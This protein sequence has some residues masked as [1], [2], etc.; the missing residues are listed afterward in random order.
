M[1]GTCPNGVTL[2]P[3]SSYAMPPGAQTNPAYYN[4]S[5]SRTSA[6]PTPAGQGW[7]T[8]N[9]GGFSLGQST[10]QSVVTPAAAGQNNVIPVN[11]NQVST[12]MLAQNQ[13][14]SNSVNYSTTSVDESQ[15][16]SRL[17]VN[18]ATMI[19]APMPFGPPAGAGRIPPAGTGSQAQFV[20]GAF[21][22]GGQPQ[23]VPGQFQN[24]A[25]GGAVPRSGYPVS[26]ANYGTAPGYSTGAQSTATYDPNTSGNVQNGWTD[27]DSVDNLR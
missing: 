9:N 10:G 13:P 27:R 7:Q 1:F 8:A 20:Q 22:P 16:E 15:D 21:S 24:N 3:P 12:P 25:P 26:P 17:A 18:D 19:R 14:V 6:V 4:G 2:T 5:G 11:S 23:I